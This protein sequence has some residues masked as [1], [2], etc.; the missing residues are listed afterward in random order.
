LRTI[1]TTLVCSSVIAGIAISVAAV[2][3]AMM[4]PVSSVGNR[5]LWMVV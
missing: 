3:V 4:K 1:S 2:V 5:P